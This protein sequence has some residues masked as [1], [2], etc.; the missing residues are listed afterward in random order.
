M[1]PH[2]E[3]A[4]SGIFDA[5]IDAADPCEALFRSVKTDGKRMSVGGNSYDLEKF[6]RIVVIG[7]GKASSRME[8]RSSLW[9]LP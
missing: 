2:S 5:A 6:E 4:L 1:S 7:A 3:K 8:I 9:L